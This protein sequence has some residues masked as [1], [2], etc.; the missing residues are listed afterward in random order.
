VVSYGLAWFYAFSDADCEHEAHTVG[1]GPES[2]EHPSFHWVNTGFGNVKNALRCTCHALR[3]RP[4]LRY[5]SELHYRFY[6]C[7]DLPSIIPRFLYVAVR[8]PPI[9]QRL[10][11]MAETQW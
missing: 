3:D 9:A 11:T 1:G 10:L 8:T 4:L 7:Y 2:A 6:R 5:L